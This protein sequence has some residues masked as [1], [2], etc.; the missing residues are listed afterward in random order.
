VEVMDGL[1]SLSM[2]LEQE[3]SYVQGRCGGMS[4]WPSTLPPKLTPARYRPVVA[5]SHPLLECPNR[6]G[7]TTSGKNAC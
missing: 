6:P 3:R 7:I 5:E 4:R 2:G 1:P